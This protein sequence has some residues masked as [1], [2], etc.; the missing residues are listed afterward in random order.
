[1]TIEE[2]VLARHSVRRYASTP[3]TKEQV[4]ELQSRIRRLNEKMTMWHLA[5]AWRITDRFGM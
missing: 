3:L 5:V 1:M 4:E 2:A